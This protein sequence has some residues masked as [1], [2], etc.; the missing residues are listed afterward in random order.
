MQVPLGVPAA[1][2]HRPAAH[3]APVIVE[4]KPDERL[5]AALAAYE[6]RLIKYEASLSAM[7]AQVEELQ[8]KLGDAKPPGAQTLNWK[9]KK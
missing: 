4:H 3:V 6:Q 9:K 5:M 8:S 2:Y 1:I 7:Q